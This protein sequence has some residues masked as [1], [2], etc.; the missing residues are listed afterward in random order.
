M[1]DLSKKQGKK[2][3]PAPISS[4][5]SVV[6]LINNYF[7]AYNSARL[8]EACKLLTQDIFQPGVTVGLS[9]SGAM[10]PAG[11]GVSAL[12]PLIRHGYIDWMISTGANLS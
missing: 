8:R 1:M 3:A 10:T 2:I 9:L 11:F 6:D 7:T 4:N 5:I 12:A